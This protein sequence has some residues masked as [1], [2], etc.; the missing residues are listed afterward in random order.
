MHQCCVHVTTAAACLP[1]HSRFPSP[2]P[3]APP[4]HT[5]MPPTLLC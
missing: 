1:L 3:P 5:C 4:P 2:F